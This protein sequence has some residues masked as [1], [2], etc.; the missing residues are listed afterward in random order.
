MMVS[1]C[2]PGR[3]VHLSGNRSL[4][5]RNPRGE[6]EE[7][8]GT[9]RD[10]DIGQLWKSSCQCSGSRRLG[11]HLVGEATYIDQLCKLDGKRR[12]IYLGR[13]TTLTTPGNATQVKQINERKERK[14]ET[15]SGRS[16]EDGE[17]GRGN[18]GI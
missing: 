7:G 9:Y 5:R 16:E 12:H 4:S 11:V 14:G 1:R 18:G 10:A 8:W 3:P 17:G 13:S 15:K 2:L 6:A